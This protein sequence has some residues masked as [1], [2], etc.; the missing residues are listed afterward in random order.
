MIDWE[1]WHS[2]R[3]L[4]HSGSYKLAAEKMGVN[5]TTIKRR[6]EALEAKVGRTLFLRE[7]GVMVPTPAF[8]SAL[9]KIENAAQHISAAESDLNPGNNELVWRRI[10]ITSVPL[11]CDKL[12]SP[13]VHRMQFIKR[14]RIELYGGDRNLELTGNREADIAMRL[15]PTRENGITGL[16]AA[17]ISY[18]TYALS[19]TA[20]TKLPWVTIDRSY[21]HLPEGKIAE[22]NSSEEGVRFTAT[23]TSS[24]LNIIESGAA[25]GLLPDFVGKQGNGL[26]RLPGTPTVSRPLW[27]MWRDGA[28]DIPHFRSTIRWILETTSYCLE[29]K[30][31]ASDFLKET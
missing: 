11:I 7:N 26:V 14:L 6:K 17:D 31:P 20:A 30:K 10:V 23:T 12:L 5:A 24:I 2:T 13:A 29:L 27:I 1:L 4:A 25:K 9:K 8:T 22:E 28:L 18:G 19:G 15:G 16:Y 3:E 21:S